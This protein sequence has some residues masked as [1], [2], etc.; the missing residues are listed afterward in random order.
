[1]NG[2]VF[3]KANWDQKFWLNVIHMSGGKGEIMGVCLKVAV[4]VPVVLVWYRRIFGRVP[5]WPEVSLKCLRE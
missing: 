5:A 1:M 2:F 3:H 4:P